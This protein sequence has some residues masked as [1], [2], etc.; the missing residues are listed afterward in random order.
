MSKPRYESVEAYFAAHGSVKA[1]TMQEVIA[2]IVKAYPQLELKLAWNVP[3]L[4]VGGH[5]VAGLAAY[6]RHLTFA[7]WS[8]SV[9]SAF[10]PRLSDYVVFKN[11]FQVPVD[12]R[13]DRELLVDMA[14]ARLAELE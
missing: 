12:W 13:I 7:P 5:Y 6:P 14:T 1:R 8:A 10:A 2:C 4:H 3:H 11:C 9:M